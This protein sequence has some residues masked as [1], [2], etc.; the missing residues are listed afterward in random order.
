MVTMAR[1]YTTHIETPS[2]PRFSTHDS[3]EEMRQSLI[4]YYNEVHA[5]DYTEKGELPSDA[6]LEEVVDAIEAFENLS[7]DETWIPSQEVW[8]LVMDTDNGTS[9]DI[10]KTEREGLVTVAYLYSC[11]ISDAE[12]NIARERLSKALEWSNDW[13]VLEKKEVPA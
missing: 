11:D 4:E 2:G 13:F 1:R 3:E 10:F 6:P 5:P 8:V 12:D 7:I 9:I